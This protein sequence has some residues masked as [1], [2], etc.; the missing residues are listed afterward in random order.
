MDGFFWPMLLFPVFF[1]ALWAGVTLL[2]SFFSGWR[3]LAGTYRGRLSVVER[4]VSM[5]SGMMS[6]FGFPASMNNVLNVAVGAE[7]VQLSLFPLFA[8]GSPPLLIPWSEIANCRSYR[9]L[10]LF[11]RLSFR[12]VQGDVKI[13][14]AG[15]AARMVGEEVAS[16]AIRRSLATA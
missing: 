8:L 2:L 10:G 6:R 16:G 4:S 12:P 3:S 14:L 5:G 11:D 13:T 1:V 15:A 9:A 7:G